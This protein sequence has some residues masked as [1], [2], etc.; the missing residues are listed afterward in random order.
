ME[1]GVEAVTPEA[2][3]LTIINES[4]LAFKAKFAGLRLENPVVSETLLRYLSNVPALTPPV[5]VVNVSV[6]SL[7]RKPLPV[8]L[9]HPL[10]VRVK[11][12]P[13]SRL[14]NGITTKLSVPVGF[15]CNITRS[16]AAKV[17]E[18]CE[19]AMPS[20]ATARARMA[21]LSFMVEGV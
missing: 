6:P 4:L 12:V 11:V 10:S 20:E 2:D 17:C 7:S 19:G 1:I 16:P 13:A 21:G 9:S 3:P 5:G 8:L 14:T 18:P 15:I